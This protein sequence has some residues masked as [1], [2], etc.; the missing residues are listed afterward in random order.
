MSNSPAAIAM[1][2]ALAAFAN[3]RPM[4]AQMPDYR[5]IYEEDARH[6]ATILAKRPAIETR[7]RIPSIKVLR[8]LD[9]K[10]I[11]LKT[12]DMPLYLYD[13]DRPVIESLYLA[14]ASDAKKAGAKPYPNERAPSELTYPVGATCMVGSGGFEHLLLLK[15]TDG[16]AVFEYS[17]RTRDDKKYDEFIAVGPYEDGHWSVNPKNPGET[18]YTETDEHGVKRLERCE[19]GADGKAT[20]LKWFGNG[21]M[22]YE[23]RKMDKDHEFMR[24]W[25]ENGY[26]HDEFVWT[27]EGGEPFTDVVMSPDGLN[28]QPAPRSLGYVVSCTRS[29]SVVNVELDM[30]AAATAAFKAAY[31]VQFHDQEL[32]PRV[33]IHI[34]ET[35]GKLKHIAFSVPVEF[36]EGGGKFR[37]E[38]DGI[39]AQDARI[40]HFAGYTL[41][42]NDYQFY[43]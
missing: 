21:Q 37:V 23:R 17:G 7:A 22:E 12:D 42:L 31:M 32:H 28:D 1:G 14:A 11:Y 19:G 33:N 4:L 25:D 2:I 38:S 39:R 30:N 43:K 5:T 24:Y 16:K 18:I 29:G 6:A 27:R 20:C 40:K 26:L 3:A 41:N 13:N 10:T 9:E 34:S 36:A 15:V 35:A 8:I